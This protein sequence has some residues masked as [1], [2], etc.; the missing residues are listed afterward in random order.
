MANGVF[1][2]DKKIHPLTMIKT[3]VH[4]FKCVGKSEEEKANFGTK[5]QALMMKFPTC[6]IMDVVYE[7]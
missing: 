4:S 5:V 3:L 1:V 6:F 2:D 7:K